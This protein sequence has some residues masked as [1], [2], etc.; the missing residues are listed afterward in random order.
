MWLFRFADGMSPEYVGFDLDGRFEQRRSG[1][2]A[3]TTY[4]L[5]AWTLQIFEIIV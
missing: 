3:L 1:R 2:C 5:W 4:S